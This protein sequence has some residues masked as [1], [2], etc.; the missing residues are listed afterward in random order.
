MFKERDEV[1]S[2]CSRTRDEV[3]SKCSRREVRLV[4]SVQG[5]R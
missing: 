1:G 4:V 5:E 3:G 2:K